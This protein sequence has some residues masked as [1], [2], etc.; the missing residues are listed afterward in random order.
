MPI[1]LGE[2]VNKKGK[3]LQRASVGEASS[4]GTCWPRSQTDAP[5]DKSSKLAKLLI[6]GVLWGGLSA[7]F[8][9][10]VAR[11]VTSDGLAFSG[12][13]TTC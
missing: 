5:V 13:E 6:R 2:E 8:A 12:F 9:S 4:S 3:R 11:A 7:S 1:T 10:E